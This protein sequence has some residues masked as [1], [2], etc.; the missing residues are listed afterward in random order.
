M[1]LFVGQRLAG[2]CGVYD[3]AGLWQWRASAANGFGSSAAPRAVCSTPA[4][5]AF[6]KV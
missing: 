3:R 5:R 2:V 1:R 4:N 6:P